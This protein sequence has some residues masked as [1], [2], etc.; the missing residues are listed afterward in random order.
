MRLFRIIIAA[1]VALTSNPLLAQSGEPS[2][3]AVDENLW[4]TFYDVPSHRFRTIRDGFVRREFES[5]SRDLVTSASYLKIESGRALPAIAERLDDVAAQ[6]TSIS[7]N[8]DDQS[9]TSVTLD[10]LFGRAHWLLAQ[11]YL[12]FAREARDA[13]NNRMAGRYL[14]ATTHHL[15]RAVLWSNARI[16]REVV[17]TLEGL[18]DLAMR[19]QDDQKAKAARKEKP[20]LRAE[21]VL[22]KLGA[23]ID[24]PVVLNVQ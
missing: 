23:V 19:M 18:R 13:N 16:D 6:M 14:W 10:K 17:K 20:I 5:A 1:C 2:F 24:R 11:H 15:E 9:V 8:I 22:V 21:K 3:V 7:K 4:I 12:Y